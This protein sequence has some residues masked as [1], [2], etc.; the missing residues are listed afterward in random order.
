MS[1]LGFYED[2]MRLDL[3]GS[4]P[5]EGRGLSKQAKTRLWRWMPAWRRSAPRHPYWSMVQREKG[6]HRKTPTLTPAAAT[7]PANP[8]RRS[9]YCWMAMAPTV[10]KLQRAIP[11]RMPKVSNYSRYDG[12]SHGSSVLLVILRYKHR[13]SKDPGSLWYLFISDP[14]SNFVSPMIVC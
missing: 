10:K 5:L 9:K 8:R 4:F 3:P 11:V 12:F 6:D 13:A 1:V 7:P 14:F 2:I